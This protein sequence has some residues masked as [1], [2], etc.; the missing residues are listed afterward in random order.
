MTL[1]EPVEL[2]AGV[3]AAKWE[4]PTVVANRIDASAPAGNESAPPTIEELDK[5]EEAAYQDGYQ[6]GYDAG[7]TQGSADA[8]ERVARLKEIFH[9]LVQPLADLDSEVEQ[10]LLQIASAVASRVIRAE[11]QTQPDLIGNMIHEAVESVASPQ[12]SVTVYLNPD[13]A[14]FVREHMD[15]PVEGPHWKIMPDDVLAPGDCRV[16]TPDAR[17]DARLDSRVQRLVAPA[18]R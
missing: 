8:K 17:A 1:S 16:E 12:T 7:F 18:F 11:L 9:T 5:I 15:Q 2:P 6:R 10:T 13:D 3:Q 14:V 4:A